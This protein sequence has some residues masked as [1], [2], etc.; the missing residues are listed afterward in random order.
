MTT[1]FDDSHTPTRWRRLDPREPT[2]AAWLAKYKREHGSG[3]TGRRFEYWAVPMDAQMNNEWTK[4]APGRNVCFLATVLD[5]DTSVLSVAPIPSASRVLFET[6]VQKTLG[7]LFA[8]SMPLLDPICKWGVKTC[9]ACFSKD[10]HPFQVESDEEVPHHYCNGCNTIWP[11]RGSAHS[12]A[13]TA[14]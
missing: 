3:W 12:E 1:T 9:P 7:F 2:F 11:P 10:L 8:L 5:D 14:S 6:A 13:Q 4:I